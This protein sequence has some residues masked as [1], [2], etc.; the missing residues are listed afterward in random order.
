MS[1]KKHLAEFKA[2]NV[3][4][5]IAI[6]GT[7]TMALSFYYSHKHRYDVVCFFDNDASKQGNFIDGIPVYAGNACVGGGNRRYY[8]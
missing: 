3:R 4:K 1:T 8:I 2:E 5:K 7:G 6:W